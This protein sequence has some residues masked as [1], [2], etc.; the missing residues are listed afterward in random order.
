MKILVT[1]A[2]GQVGSALID[3]LIE[4]YGVDSIIATDIV[5]NIN[6]KVKFRTLDVTDSSAVEKLFDEYK[7]NE[8]YH[9]A[10]LLSATGEKNPLKLWDINIGGT[11]NMLEAIRKHHS[12]MFIPSSIAA[13]GDSTPKEDTPQVT[14]Q[15]PDTIYGI[16][17]VSGE[18]LCDYYVKKYSLD[19]RG[20]RFP[21]LI[22]YET[23]PGGGTTDYAVHVYYSAL[24]DEPYF[25]CNI[26]KGTYMDFMYM[27]DAIDAVIKLMQAPKENLQHF[28]AYNITAMSIEP[29]DVFRSIKKYVPNFTY[30][31]KVDEVL[32][33]IAKGWPDRLDATQARKDWGFSPNYDLDAMT[34]DMLENIKKRKDD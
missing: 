25:E 23:L 22:S 31:Y 34:R 4:L 32:Q 20:V 12:R 18:L 29:E 5:E 16:S 28:N 15:R 2:N 11:L 13:F 33:N 26:E 21:G 19:I 24:K 7:F 17:K 8:V 10:A 27:K 1:G 9:L 6:S 3:K 14:I 30:E